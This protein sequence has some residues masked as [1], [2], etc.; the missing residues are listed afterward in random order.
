[1][2]CFPIEKVSDL[3]NLH[4]KLLLRVASTIFDIH[5]QSKHCGKVFCI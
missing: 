1:M 5:K 2:I 4:L 3:W